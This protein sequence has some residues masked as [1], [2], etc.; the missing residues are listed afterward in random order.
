M[1]LRIGD[2]AVIAIVAAAALTIWLFP[3]SG[4]IGRFAEVRVDGNLK[5][6]LDLRGGNAEYNFA[7]VTLRVEDGY[8]YAPHAECPDL[9]CVR[10]GKISKPG[11]AIVC[12]PNRVSV[13]IKGEAEVDAIVGG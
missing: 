1:K 8:V 6:T 7:G 5:E 12:V 3:Q 10:R 13:E 9:V 4:G 11:Q 2:I